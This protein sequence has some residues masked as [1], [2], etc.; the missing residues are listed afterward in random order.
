MGIH[1][2]AG[3]G[4]IYRYYRG[5]LR[6]LY[7]PAHIPNAI[8]F[9][10]DRSCAYYTG[11]TSG[12]VMRQPLDSTHGWPKG[13]PQVFVDLRDQDSAPDGAVTDAQG[14]LWLARWGGACVSAFA[15]DGSWIRDIALPAAHITCPAFGGADL[16]DLV[17]STG[18][19]ARRLGA[20]RRLFGRRPKPLFLFD[21]ELGQAGPAHVAHVVD[22]LYVP[23]A[24]REAQRKEEPRV[25]SG[26]RL[27]PVERHREASASV[28]G[29][30]QRFLPQGL[31]PSFGVSG[32]DLARDGAA[33]GTERERESGRILG[34]GEPHLRDVGPGYGD[35]PEVRGLLGRTERK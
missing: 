33:K 29:H 1:A 31:D 7:G 6:Q 21:T 3:A 26:I 15:P 23:V 11:T 32:G 2:E 30:R 17:A 25:A 27:A 28:E 19:L 22:E 14:T 9:A 12:V 35:G 34:G 4:A 18:F 8:C 16:R 24:A 20:P 10:P 13:D 5:T